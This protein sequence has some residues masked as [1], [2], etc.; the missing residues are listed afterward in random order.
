[1]R[2]TF[3]N[4]LKW[5]V[6]IA[7]ITFVLAAIFSIFSNYI[8]DGLTWILGIIVVFT[9]V[10]IG[11][12][13]DMIGIA[14]T[15]ADEIPFHSMAANKVYGSKYA[16]RIVRNA[17]KVASFCNDVIGDIAGIVSG[18]ASAIVIVQLAIQ[19]SIG[20][21]SVKEYV[22][23]VLFTSFIAA[24]TVGGKAFGKTF[25]INYSKQIILQAGKLF[26]FLDEKFHIVII[27]EN[28][29]R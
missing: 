26:Q 12:V 23:S 17:D 14:S 27:K 29:K 20:S 3:K 22:I 9:I 2:K 18:T 24:F 10:F 11:I 8:L 13:F 6:S 7:V 15:S 21:G 19:F 4:S 25:A 28:R 5:S 1:M 16:I